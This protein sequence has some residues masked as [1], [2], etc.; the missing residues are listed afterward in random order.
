W[1]PDGAALAFL[2]G[3]ELRYNAYI[4]DRLALADVGSGRV[5]ELTEKLDRGIYS[6][7]FASG[8]GS[9]VFAVEDDGWQYPA[10]VATADGAITRLGT[11]MVVHQLATA[12]GHTAVLASSDAAPTE[13]FALED[14]R[15]RPLSAHNQALFAELA[16][17][18]VADIAFKTRDG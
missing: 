10:Q 12:A 2:H 8:G 6:P 7:R 5:R 16:L 9:L 15:L 17:G 1:S 18:S 11:Q 13:V 3:Q 4:D 14:G